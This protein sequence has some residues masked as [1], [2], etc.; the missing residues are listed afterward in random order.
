[1]ASQRTGVLLWFRSGSR[2]EHNIFV[3]R[4]NYVDRIW[5]SSLIL[6]KSMQVFFLGIFNL[7]RRASWLLMPRSWIQYV[8]M[9]RIKI[10]IDLEIIN[11][12]YQDLDTA[13]SNRR[14]QW[15]NQWRAYSKLTCC[16]L[17]DLEM[18]T[19]TWWRSFPPLWRH[20]FAFQ[21]TLER[22]I[23]F[24]ATLP[25][26]LIQL[27]VDSNMTTGYFVLIWSGPEHNKRSKNCWV[28]CCQWRMN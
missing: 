28:G 1:M 23:S 20:Y 8:L 9:D 19:C 26:L 24:R 14:S 17:S 21:I 18:I 22:K 11:G 13:T 15:G 10:W 16:V 6:T 5:I 12:A 3:K 2:I 27:V 7:N 4:R 25:H